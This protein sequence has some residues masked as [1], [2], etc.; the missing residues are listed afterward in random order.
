MGV[1]EPEHLEQLHAYYK[2]S[3]LQYSSILDEYD[4]AH[5]RALNARNKSQFPD[6][7]MWNPPGKLLTEEERTL[8]MG[9]SGDIVYYQKLLLCDTNTKRMIY[10][11]AR[12][13][14]AKVCS[15][16]VS[17][18]EHVTHPRFGC[19]KSLFTH[20]FSSE[21]TFWVLLDVYPEA[22]Y[23]KECKMWH[24]P[25]DKPLSERCII[26]LNGVSYPLV[27]ACDKTSLW[28][29]NYCT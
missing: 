13:P 26:Q 4:R 18:K 24:V 29:L 10:F 8:L 28:F 2:R 7:Q 11:S 3:N 22:T 21:V 6:K 16:F 9:P 23:D 17:L 14:E 15:S 25:V 12:T 19:I 5:C 20:S 27:V 1:L